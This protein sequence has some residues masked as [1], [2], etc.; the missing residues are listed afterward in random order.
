VA[1]H[2]LV[3]RDLQPALEI[4]VLIRGI[5]WSKSLEEALEVTKQQRLVLVDRE[6]ERRVQGLEVDAPGL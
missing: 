3:D 4:V 6:A 1:V 2:R 5:V